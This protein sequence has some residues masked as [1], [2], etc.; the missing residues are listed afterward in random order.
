[1][2]RRPLILAIALSGLAGPGALRAEDAAPG[3]GDRLRVLEASA[4]DFAVAAAAHR[5]G[6]LAA[7]VEAYRNALAKD[8]GFVEAQVNLARALADLGQLDEADGWLD[9][10]L[11]QRPDYYA[12]FKVQGLVA[13]RRGQAELG[14]EALTRARRLRP[15]DPECLTNLGAALLGQGRLAEASEVLARGAKL[16]PSSPG[17]A[18]NLALAR[19]RASD[20]GRAAYHY[21]RFLALAPADHPLRPPVEQRLAELGGASPSAVSAE[22]PRLRAEP[23]APDPETREQEQ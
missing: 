2:R 15:D 6:D 12:V 23:P 20:P 18:L 13:L 14:V 21:K 10:A 5:R 1:V 7:A 22:P 11:A 16:A 19:D 17:A 4:A 3:E 9:R 8:A